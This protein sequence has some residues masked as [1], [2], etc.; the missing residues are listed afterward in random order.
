MTP[1][2][3]NS[4][5]DFIEVLTTSIHVKIKEILPV[6]PYALAGLDSISGL[7][8]KKSYPEKN[9]TEFVA[10]EGQSANNNHFQLQQKGIKNGIYYIVLADLVGS[11]QFLKKHG[12]AKASDRIIKFVE[13]GIKALDMNEHENT[14]AFLKEVG[15]CVLLIFQHFSDVQQ[16][17]DSFK[18]LLDDLNPTQMEPYSIRTCVHIGEVCLH[19]ANP[20]CLSVSETFKMEKLVGADKLVLSEI[21]A[22]IAAPTINKINFQLKPFTASNGQ[23]MHELMNT[24]VVFDT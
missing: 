2:N 7:T 1:F 17:H 24:V 3:Y 9:N 4:I 12:N 20:L 22:H 23:T 14:S 10:I 13:S 21:A 5:L 8:K 18:E 15:D 6:W 19:D 16:W 11:T